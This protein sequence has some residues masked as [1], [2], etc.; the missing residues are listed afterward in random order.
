MVEAAQNEDVKSDEY[1]PSN[2]EQLLIVTH[3]GDDA[4]IDKKFK[5]TVVLSRE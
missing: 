1:T 2:E 5:S 3:M 4:I